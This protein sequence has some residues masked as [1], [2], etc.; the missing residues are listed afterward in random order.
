MFSVSS[1]L[2]LH[3]D[4]GSNFLVFSTQCDLA[5][6]FHGKRHSFP[7]F[8]PRFHSIPFSSGVISSGSYNYLEAA[9]DF[10]SRTCSLPTYDFSVPAANLK[11]LPPSPAPFFLIVYFSSFDFT[12]VYSMS[13]L[14]LDFVE[15]SGGARLRT[16]H[17]VTRNGGAVRVRPHAQI[18][19]T[20]PALV[21]EK[22]FK[23]RVAP[24]P[25]VP[26]KKWKDIL[27]FDTS[28]TEQLDPEYRKYYQY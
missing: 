6:F 2:T 22:K 7:E 20:T 24:A 5:V 10:W 9:T 13:S 23:G 25:Y 12:C 14:Y 28:N 19:D 4:R 1:V 21:S 27:R 3:F 8:F 11:R 17:S 18:S 26:D 16:P 15:Q